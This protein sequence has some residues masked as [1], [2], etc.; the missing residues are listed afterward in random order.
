VAGPVPTSDAIEEGLSPDFLLAPPFSYATPEVGRLGQW[1]IRLVE[2]CTGQRRIHQLYEMYRLRQRPPELFW[3]DALAAMRIELAVA[4]APAD[5]VPAQGPLLVVANHPFG[6]V[7]G[8]V[9]CALVAQARDDYR[10]MTHRILQRVPE[11]R[12]YILPVDFAGTPEATETNL[13]SR[14]LARGLLDRGGALIVFPAGGVAAAAHPAARPAERPWGTFA[15]RLALATGAEV[16]PVHFR[17]RN[18]RLF[19]AAG[20][21]HQ[22][23]RYALLLNEVRNKIG[24]RV[25]IAIGERIAHAELRALGSPREVTLHLRRRTED[26]APQLEAHHS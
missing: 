1:L 24:T 16:L 5:S 6:V 7:D 3:Q 8:M 14:Q 21:L 26:L 15:A 18:S 13:R 22:T 4:R 23:L 11:A 9:L 19:H 20:T 12:R 17:G 10:I 2:R 25:E